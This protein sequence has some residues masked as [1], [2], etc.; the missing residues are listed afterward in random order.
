MLY[1]LV[2]KNILGEYK[3]IS[4]HNSDYFKK[5]EYTDYED[6]VA[7]NDLVNY[8]TSFNSAKHLKSS[9][10]RESIISVD[11]LDS[12]LYVAVYNSKCEKFQILNG[13]LY[14]KDKTLLNNQDLLAKIM[15]KY[16]EENDY[17]LFLNLSNELR[18]INPRISVNL[19][20]VSGILQ[21]YASN[22][23][24][25][26]KSNRLNLNIINNT[27]TKLYLTPISEVDNLTR[28]VLINY[29]NQYKNICKKKYKVRK[30]EK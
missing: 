14:K 15:F 24:D 12:E 16:T 9:L 5:E 10:L 4:I 6:L 3:I 26:R 7:Y 18:D 20:K 27:I 19:A 8:T 21:E 30:I 25:Y 23:T 11:D 17:Q 29:L 22:D 28:Y 13:V 2:I 1:C